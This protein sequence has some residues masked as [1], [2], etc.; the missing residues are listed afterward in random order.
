MTMTDMAAAHA[1]AKAAAPGVST[2]EF[3]GKLVLQILVVVVFGLQKL[4][5]DIDA[6]EELLIAVVAGIEAIYILGRSIIKSVLAK[7][8]VPPAGEGIDPNNHRNCP[9]QRTGDIE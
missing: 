6:S 8:A 5:L 3:Q 4:G 9:I 7:Q 2:T 1:L